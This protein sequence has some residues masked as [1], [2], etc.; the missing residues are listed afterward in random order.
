MSWAIPCACGAMLR[1]ASCWT[2]WTCACCRTEIRRSDAILLEKVL[3]SEDE[4]GENLGHGNVLG[5][6]PRDRF[7]PAL[8]RERGTQPRILPSPS[9]RCSANVA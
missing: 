5:G 1:V 4:P 3:D 7:A 8:V 2:C 9:K 6:T